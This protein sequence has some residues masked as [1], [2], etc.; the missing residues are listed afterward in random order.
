MPHYTQLSG[1]ERSRISALLQLGKSRREIAF[2]LGRSPSTISRELRRNIYPSQH[3]YRPWDA[4]RM[5]KIRRRERPYTSKVG[6]RTRQWIE[7]KLKHQWSPEQIAGRI[8]IELG[9]RV[10][11]EWIY[12]WILKDRAK[13][14]LLYLNL[15]RSHR[16]HKKR[17]GVPRKSNTRFAEA[18]SIDQRPEIVEKRARSGDWE[19]DT[20]VGL[21]Q[22]SGIVSLVERISCFTRLKLLPRRH[23]NKVKDA[24]IE[25]LEKTEG[26]K[27]T[28]T[29]DRG[30]EFAFYRQ[31]EDQLGVD[32]YF[33]HPYCSYERGTNENLNGLVRQYFPKKTDLTLVDPRQVKKV[34]WLL[35][36][37]P[38]KKLGYL[39]PYEAYFGF[40]PY[41]R[42]RDKPDLRD[43]KQQYR[44]Q[45]AKE[46]CY[47][48]QQLT[49][50]VALHA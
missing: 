10:S 15:R 21:K 9:A 23:A 43:W 4:H 25:L 35:N 11:H 27:H 45:K 26:P 24:V 19:G 37:R 42:N 14:G 12:Q 3:S 7:A 8:H 6:F 40:C 38:R 30:S 28:I 33:A 29:F 22:E 36:H 31:M 48:T 50:D 1:E 32:T 47:N 46:L 5:A 16:K 2:A 20:L 49:P 17:Y 44:R 18:R 34:E 39:T 13:G 41:P